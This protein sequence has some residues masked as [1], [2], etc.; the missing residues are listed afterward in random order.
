MNTHVKCMHTHIIC[1]YMQLFVY[2][3]VEEVRDGP[4][5]SDYPSCLELLD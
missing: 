2:E 3:W 1:I 5:I 4:P